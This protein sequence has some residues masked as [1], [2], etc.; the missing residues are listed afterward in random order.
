MY[1][2]NANVYPFREMSR[3]VG[4]RRANFVPFAIC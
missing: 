1:R 4:T 2:V 3:P